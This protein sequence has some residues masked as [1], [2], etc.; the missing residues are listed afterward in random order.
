MI[1]N[2]IIILLEY[3]LIFPI[4]Q[5]RC[6]ERKKI[7][8]SDSGMQIYTALLT[9]KTTQNCTE[10]LSG[11]KNSKN[12]EDNGL[13]WPEKVSRGDLGCTICFA[14]FHYIDLKQWMCRISDKV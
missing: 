5:E 12:S 11:R 1:K 3:G 2:I 4:N 13:Q 14:N 8:I 7:I 10:I 6:K 9:I